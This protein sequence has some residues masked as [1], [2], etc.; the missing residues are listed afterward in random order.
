MRT[1][2]EP[3]GIKMTSD[4]LQRYDMTV[5]NKFIVPASVPNYKALYE[6]YDYSSSFYKRDLN[7][8]LVA[9]FFECTEEIGVKNDFLI[10]FDI[11]QTEKSKSEENDIIYSNKT[12]FEYLITLCRKEIKAAFSRFL[13]H[14]AIAVFAF[15]CWVVIRSG[16]SESEAIVSQFFTQALPV[17]IW[18][19]L[20]LGIS[21]FVFRIKTQMKEIR[22]C[23]KIMNSPI[24]FNYV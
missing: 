22:L 10:R 14:F 18:V 3:P 11:P 1:I 13:I 8:D 7:E 17:G 16:V 12:Y 20:L 6:I 21:R 24:E 2:G 4:I 5:D 9:Y 19:L 15:I 23:R